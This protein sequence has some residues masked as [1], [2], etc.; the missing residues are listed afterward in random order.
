MPDVEILQSTIS[1]VP[2]KGKA[3]I[4]EGIRPLDGQFHQPISQSTGYDT[5]SQDTNANA[6]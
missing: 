6:P 2:G 1:S 3:V 4:D 5:S